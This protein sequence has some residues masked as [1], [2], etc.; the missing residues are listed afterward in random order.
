MNEIRVYISFVNIQRVKENP[1][2]T[3]LTSEARYHAE[4]LVVVMPHFILVEMTDV[5]K[6][7]DLDR[8]T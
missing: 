5:R 3:K 2:A 6:E 8:E 1:W 7:N 4:R